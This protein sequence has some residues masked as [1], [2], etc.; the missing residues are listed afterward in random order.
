MIS[1]DEAFAII[2]AAAPVDSVMAPIADAGGRV[3][4]KNVVA[5][6]TQ[7]PFD[8]SAMDGYAVRFEEVQKEGATLTVIGE[9]R[10]GGA[11]ESTVGPGEAVRIFTGGVVPPGAD[12]ILIQEDAD[13]D[14]DRLTVKV[15]QPAP[16]HIRRAGRDF[17]EGDVIKTA[18]ARLSPIDL[19]LIA[20]SNGESVEVR[21]KPM[22]AYFDNGDEIRDPGEP[23]GPGE[24]I[25]SN[26]FA[27]DALIRQWGGAP[28]YLG[29]AIDQHDAVVEKFEQG[30]MADVIVPIGGASVGDHDHCRA[31]FTG[32]GGTFLFEKVAVKPGKPTWFGA[33]GAASDGGAWVLGLPGN[34]ASAIVCA[35]LFLKP[36]LGAL[37][38]AVDPHGVIHAPLLTALPPAGNRECFLRGRLEERRDVL[39]VSPFDDQDSSLLGPLA[40]ANILIRRHANAPAL[41]IGDSVVCHPFGAGVKW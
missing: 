29:R 16:R 19:A 5:G 38:G 33:V 10:A 12:H 40:G 23:L 8:A 2:R 4:A 26:R 21:R 31:A 22:V 13:R 24:I 35:T 39:C 17:R 14:E 1:V 9:A 28:R 30:R 27:I 11:F 25:G 18:G 32:V 41:E 6:L 3:L 20:A 34:P 37:L 36:L 15:R 7:P